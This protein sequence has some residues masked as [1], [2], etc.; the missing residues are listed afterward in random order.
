MNLRLVWETE[1]GGWE[2]RDDSGDEER[3][4]KLELVREREG[5]R[6]SSLCMMGVWLL[7]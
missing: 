3:V 7:R 1:S 5:E 6:E 4:G 2:G